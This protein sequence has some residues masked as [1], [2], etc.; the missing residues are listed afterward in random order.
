[1]RK[2]LITSDLHYERIESEMR[3][4]ILN[5][6]IDSIVT[7]RPELFIIAGDTVD[8]S[9]LR[10]ETDDF[11][12]LIYF[13]KR[14]SEVCS[15]NNVRFIVLRGTPSHD[16]DVMKTIHNI[17]CGFEYIDEITYMK[18]ESMSI[19]FI[20]EPFYPS[21]EE[22]LNE[23]NEKPVSDIVV[24]HGM[25][26]FAIPQLRQTDSKF[27]LSRSIVMKG[28]DLEKR[29]LYCCIG[30]HVHSDIKNNNIYY[31]NRIINERGH[32][33]TNGI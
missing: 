28:T 11:R 33:H 19:L 8:R 30:G 10:V 7:I 32:S 29:S 1:M 9:D 26:D 5:H 6:V 22:F 2:I 24:F 23:L 17:T 4:D 20:P 25:V 13:I 27:N 31:T 15:D 14:V 21:Y 18:F 16:G 3:G 12:D